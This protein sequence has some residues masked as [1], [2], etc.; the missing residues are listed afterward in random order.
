MIKP[1]LAK[2]EY[3]NIEFK[4]EDAEALKV[5][6]IKI[7]SATYYNNEDQPKIESFHH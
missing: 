1:A 4:E 5:N 2:V 7:K 3:I 6:D